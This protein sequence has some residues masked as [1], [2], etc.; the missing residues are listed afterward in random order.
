MDRI[1]LLMATLTPSAVLLL[2]AVAGIFVLVIGCIA[3]LIL[4]LMRR[5]ADI[6]TLSAKLEAA[7][8]ELESVTGQRDAAEAA[9]ERFVTLADGASEVWTRTPFEPPD[10]YAERMAESIPIIAAANL[11]GGVGKTTLAANLAAWFDARGERVLLID[12]DYQGSLTA[13]ALGGDARGRDFGAPGA[14]TLLRGEMPKVFPMAGAESNSGVIDA[15][16]PLLNEESRLLFRWLLGLEPG[17]V[18]Y[19]LASLL[20]APRVQTIYDRVIID[21]PPR[22]T[23]S[24]VNALCAATHLVIPTQLNGLST[25]A[26]QS[27][28]ATLDALRPRPLPPVQRYRILG[29]QKTWS[30]ERMS[31]AE[32]AAVAE[33]DRMLA[34]R[35]EPPGLFLRDAILPN[36]SGFQRAAGRGLAYRTE[37]SV[38]PELDRLGA[39]IGRFAPSFAEE[40]EEE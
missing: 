33:I 19:R 16:Y 31:R 30:T 9:L 11:K 15:S 24:L 10:G 36:M 7:E 27:F 32:L 39:R 38:R 13:M 28:L 23:L 21:T 17:D 40:L 12:L 29:M 8:D 37:P 3:V 14:R 2:V 20:L 1:E 5:S 25:E 22:V 26:V 4:A 35:G 34:M 6:G 18:R